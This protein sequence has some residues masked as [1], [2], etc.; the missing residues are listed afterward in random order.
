MAEHS[1]EGEALFE[2]NKSQKVGDDREMPAAETAQQEPPV[3]FEQRVLG[4]LQSL[5]EAKDYLL[6]SMPEMYKELKGT[7]AGHATRLAATEEK[8]AALEA[9]VT[10][11]KGSN[12][13]LT[14]KV[15]ALRVGQ[16]KIESEVRKQQSQGTSAA[17]VERLRE[18]VTQVE[19]NNVVGAPDHKVSDLA[20]QVE[21]SLRSQHDHD[22][23]LLG[24]PETHDETPHSL[25]NTIQDKLDPQASERGAVV[26]E[27]R[28]MGRKT[29]QPGDKTRAVLV[30][31]ASHGDKADAF[32]RKP[33]LRANSISIQPY[34]TRTQQTAKQRLMPACK[35]LY[36]EGKHPTWRGSQLF[37]REHDEAAPKLY[38]PPPPP[39]PATGTTGPASDGGGTGRGGGA[40]RG[41]AGRGGAGRGGAGRGGGQN[42][43]RGRGRNTYC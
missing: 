30:T 23:V 22:V 32:K 42:A 24:V 20:E 41:G 43:G 29:L 21:M 34:L 31:L 35:M 19:G 33:A 9:E 5:Q 27:A 3:P 7:I 1:R 10:Q 16:Q 15:E 37:Y 17:A 2:Q 4:N 13:E 28:R 26:Q 38:L 14:A 40:G 36:S 25:R 6:R 8:T 18:R 39:P 11:L 12:S